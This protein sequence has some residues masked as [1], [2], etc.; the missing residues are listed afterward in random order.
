MNILVSDFDGTLTQYDFFDQVRKRWPM[1][2]EVDPWNK[3]LAGEITHFEALAGIFSRIRASEADLRELMQSMELDPR[4]AESMKALREKGWEVIIASAGCDWYIRRLLEGAGVSVPL[5]ANPGL[6][7]PDHGLIMS[8]PADA[9]FRSS[10]T[11]VDKVAVVR[12][13]IQRADQVA[14]A[15]DGPPDLPAALLVKPE[16]RFARGWL[17]N[18]LREQREAFHPFHHW[19]EIADQLPR[20]A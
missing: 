13:A 14:F 3:F 16:F 19:S 10:T 9:R 5:H 15:G 11:G 17:A 8:F 7:S 1:P 18:A 4:L 20:L 2:P 12:D 6:F